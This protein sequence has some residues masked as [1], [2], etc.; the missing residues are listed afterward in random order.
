MLKLLLLDVNN[1]I[2][3]G[4]ARCDKRSKNAN[5]EAINE[6]EKCPCHSLYTYHE[7]PYGVT[8]CSAYRSIGSKRLFL[9]TISE[10]IE[11]FPFSTQVCTDQTMI[12]NTSIIF[13]SPNRCPI[14]CSCPSIRTQELSVNNVKYTQQIPINLLINR[15][16]HS[17][18]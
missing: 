18:T 15:F 3:Y 17:N 13:I 7:I 5:F 2:H 6:R 1:L 8:S 9:S 11:F 10:M 14:S 4:T 12:A 16:T